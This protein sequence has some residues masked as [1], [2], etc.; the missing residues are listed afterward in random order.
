LAGAQVTEDVSSI[1][2]SGL[3]IKIQA[4]SAD[5]ITHVK[6]GKAPIS[7]ASHQHLNGEILDLLNAKEILALGLE[8]AEDNGGGF[9]FVKTM[10]EI[11]GQLIPPD[12]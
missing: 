2:E 3:I 12:C 1:W 10:A 9:P 6:P 4:P 8:Y 7:C 5:E 11:A